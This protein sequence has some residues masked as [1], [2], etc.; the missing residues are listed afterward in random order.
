MHTTHNNPFFSLSALPE[1]S[2][3]IDWDY[4]RRN[5]STPGLVDSFQKQFEALTVPYPKDTTTARLEEHKK[6]VVS[7]V[8]K[9]STL[10]YYCVYF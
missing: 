9:A 2:E 6:Q 3:P 10:I 1:K 8:D 4:Y 7:L 5:I